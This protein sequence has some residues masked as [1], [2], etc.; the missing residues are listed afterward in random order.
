MKITPLIVILVIA[1]II[2]IFILIWVIK[3]ICRHRGKKLF[4]NN[5]KH[6]YDRVDELDE[7]EIEFQRILD[8]KHSFNFQNEVCK[9]FSILIL[10]FF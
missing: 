10:L 3:K 2:L 5:V 7:E 1:S 8:N 9:F 4:Q 6:L